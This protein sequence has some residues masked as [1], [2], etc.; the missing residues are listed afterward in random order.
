MK[1]YRIIHIIANVIAFGVLAVFLI[2]AIAVWDSIPDTIG[3]HFDANIEEEIAD[4]NIYGSKW[5][6]LFPF[7]AG[8]GLLGIF[9][10][11]GHIAN[12]VNL[13]LKV[14]EQGEKLTRAAVN[15]YLDALKVCWGIAFAHWADCVIH[16]HGMYTLIPVIGVLILFFG[17]L[18]LSLAL[19]VI[20]KNMSL[21]KAA[22]KKHEWSI[23]HREVIKDALAY[24]IV[25][26][27]TSVASFTFLGGYLVYGGACLTGSVFISDR[28]RTADLR[29]MM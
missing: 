29:I 16:Q 17:L 6:A 2:Y 23:E 24:R 27:T 12:K 8:F 10:F 15:L 28:V 22:D 4:F 25:H 7:V 9:S 1:T 26:L 20:R 3:V 21:V 19:L 13:G 14:D 11:G 5:F 18:V